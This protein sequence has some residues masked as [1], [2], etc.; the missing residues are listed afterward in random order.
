RLRGPPDLC[1]NVMWLTLARRKDRYDPSGVTT[2]GSTAMEMFWTASS[3]PG[4][5]RRGG[6]SVNTE[7]VVL[8]RRVAAADRNAMHVLFSNH[9][10]AVYRFVLQRLRDKALAEDV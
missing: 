10:V 7:D 8:M 6:R 2:D 5:V 9:H 1:P 4:P 3:H